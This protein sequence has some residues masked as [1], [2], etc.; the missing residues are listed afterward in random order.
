ML[1]ARPALAADAGAG[2]CADAGDDAT[3]VVDTV[4]L[5]HRLIHCDPGND[6]PTLAAVD[7]LDRLQNNIS[8]IILRIL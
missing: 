4:P 1:T 7:R 6:C 8:R 5:E 3:P 2:A